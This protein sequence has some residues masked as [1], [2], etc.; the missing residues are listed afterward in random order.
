MAYFTDTQ[1]S[2]MEELV[3]KGCAVVVLSPV[4]LGGLSPEELVDLMKM[5]ARIAIGI[6]REL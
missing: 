1:I 6:H 3:K 5:A 4:E 2:V